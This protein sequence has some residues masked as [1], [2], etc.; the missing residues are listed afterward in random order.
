MFLKYNTFQSLKTISAPNE[1]LS[2]RITNNKTTNCEFSKS[3]NNLILRNNSLFSF[4]VS[5]NNKI[6]KNNSDINNVVIATP[7]F[8]SKNKSI[9]SKMKLM[10]NLW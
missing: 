5:D 1:V 2:R 9:S 7:H 6:K 10:T 3:N 4:N 8:N